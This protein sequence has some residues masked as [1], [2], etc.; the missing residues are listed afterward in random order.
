MLS[1]TDVQENIRRL[2]K[3]KPDAVTGPRYFNSDSTP[4]CIVGH[5]I[6]F[7][8]AKDAGSQIMIGNGFIFA[9]KQAVDLPWEKLGI[10][11]PGKIQRRWISKV[12]QLQDEGHTWRVAVNAADEEFYE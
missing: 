10:R 9:K 7:L 5:V 4:C 6:E 11:S 8:G 3:M 2:A 1:F 12:Q